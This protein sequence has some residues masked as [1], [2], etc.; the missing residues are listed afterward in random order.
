LSPEELK[1]R[2]T[3]L[4]DSISHV[5][6]HFT[7]RGLLERHKLI[8][9]SMLTFRILQRNGELNPKEVEHLILNKADP[10]PTSL[11]E[12]LKGFLNDVVWANIK[13]LEVLPVFNNLGSSLES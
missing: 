2:I 8:V 7:R 11:P 13:G 4:I 1:E 6:F 5:A 3:A 12:P 9:S 10:N